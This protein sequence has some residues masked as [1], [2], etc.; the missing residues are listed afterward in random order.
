M[1]GSAP[2]PKK[3]WLTH[4]SIQSGE[5]RRVAAWKKE[6]GIPVIIDEFGYEGDLPFGWGIC[7]PSNL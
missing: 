6:Y 2:F 1:I 5:V 7:L 4:A 3:K